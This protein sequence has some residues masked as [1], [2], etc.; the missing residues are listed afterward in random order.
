M[1]PRALRFAMNPATLEKSYMQ[2]F[3]EEPREE[4]GGRRVRYNN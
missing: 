3:S 4:F 1:V 2:S